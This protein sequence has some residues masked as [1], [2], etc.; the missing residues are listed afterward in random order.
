MFSPQTILTE[1]DNGVYAIVVVNGLAKCLS[2]ARQ[3]LHQTG[4]CEVVLS[5]E[6]G[7][8]VD[9]RVGSHEAQEL[10]SGFCSFSGF[11]LATN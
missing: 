5:L 9:A 11:I 4:S 6:K 10:N 3:G 2:Y 7:D 1:T 8:T